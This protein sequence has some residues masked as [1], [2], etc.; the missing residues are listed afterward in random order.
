MVEMYVKSFKDAF[1]FA[2]S[3]ASSKGWTMARTVLLLIGLA[4]WTPNAMWGDVVG[5]NL[6][7]NPGFETGS[8]GAWTL[9]ANDC[10]MFGDNPCDAWHVTSDNSQSGS[11]SLED[12]GNTEVVQYFTPTPGSVVDDVSFWFMQD[13]AMMFGYEL[14]YTDGTTSMGVLFPTNDDWEYYNITSSVDPDKM[15]DG[16]GFVNYSS[17][18]GNGPAWLDDVVVDPPGIPTSTP[19]PGSLLLLGVGVVMLGGTMY[20]KSLLQ[21]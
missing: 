6:V 16:I 15:L 13:P 18:D 17:P 7:T 4:A 1:R 11:Y 10:G 20:R 14:F 21:A 2:G 19:E 5:T 9:G 8:M 12:T 3:S